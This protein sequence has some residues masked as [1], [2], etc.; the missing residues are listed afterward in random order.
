MMAAARRAHG[1]GPKEIEMASFRIRF[2]NDL[3]S[4]DGRAFH[5]C[6][7]ELEIGEAESAEQAIEAAKKEFERLEHV[8]D[9][10]LRARSVECEPWLER[11]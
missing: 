4:S 6:Q 8:P 7:R 5:V 9:W 3:L 2:C 11:A 10:R 1:L